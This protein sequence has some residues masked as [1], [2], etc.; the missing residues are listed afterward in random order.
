MASG[1]TSKPDSTCCVPCAAHRTGATEA[2]GSSTHA[3]A[4]VDS[5]EIEIGN[6]NVKTEKHTHPTKNTGGI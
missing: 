6:A 2:C 3:Q 4:S 5:K 1:A